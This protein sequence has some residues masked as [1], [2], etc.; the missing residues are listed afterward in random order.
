MIRGSRVG[1]KQIH[2]EAKL[3]GIASAREGAR[4]LRIVALSLNVWE[5]FEFKP[6]L[7]GK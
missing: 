4:E 2:W 1:W 7:L 5:R 6:S 3:E